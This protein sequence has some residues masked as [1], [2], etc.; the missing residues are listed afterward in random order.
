MGPAATTPHYIPLNKVNI[1]N[2]SCFTSYAP[3]GDVGGGSD[4]KANELL[5]ADPLD[6]SHPFSEKLRM[7]PRALREAVPEE[8][9]GE[10]FSEILPAVGQITPILQNIARRKRGSRRKYLGFSWPAAEPPSA[11]SHCW[12]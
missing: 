8:V 11:W 7:I 10:D 12:K 2:P 4:D 1:P 6:S 5:E 3:D 9:T